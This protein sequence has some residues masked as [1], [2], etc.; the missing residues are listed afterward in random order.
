ME[1]ILLNNNSMFMEE[2][3]RILVCNDR[4]E[5][6]KYL[7]VFYVFKKDPMILVDELEKLIK[8]YNI[9]K[10]IKF[11]SCVNFVK[12]E[13]ENNLLRLNK[14]VR[15]KLMELNNNYRIVDVPLMNNKNI[16]EVSPKDIA[17]MMTKKVSN[18]YN[19][20]TNVEM[21]MRCK[22]YD[23]VLSPNIYEIIN[24]FENTS[25]WIPNIILQEKSKILQKKMAKWFINVMCECIKINNFHTCY[26]IYAGFNMICVSRLKYLFTKNIKIK[27]GLIDTLFNPSFNFRNY[28]EKIKE[29][30]INNFVLPYFG[31]FS[32]DINMLNEIPLYNDES[33]NNDV[34]D[35]FYNVVVN[36]LCHQKK[37]QINEK[38][39]FN[40][41]EYFKEIEIIRDPILLWEKSK[42][43]IGVGNLTSSVKLEKTDIEKLTHKSSKY[44]ATSIQF[45]NIGVKSVSKRSSR[46]LMNSVKLDKI[47]MNFVELN[48]INEFTN[49]MKRNICT[50]TNEDI[51]VWLNVIGYGKYESTF[52]LR[53][54][55]G[56]MLPFM[57]EKYLVE[58]LC[59]NEKDIDKLMDIINRFV[60]E[61]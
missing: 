28:R 15:N 35:K 34:I 4:E 49:R 24:N 20:I 61:K 1:I 12:L 46:Y 38:T 32:A 18:K 51:C 22:E 40:L 42:K 55:T 25:Y 3:K 26:A 37:F 47:D 19:K 7:T 57:N 54:I 43:I 56:I 39:N 6:L 58:I 14:G 50:W 60:N 11:E 31:I 30:N 2:M 53:N 23:K 13:L 44:L 10:K 33:I 29:L 52:R 8:R 41:S 21:L 27:L 16:F 59:V 9:N 17:I 48:E 5:Q 36:V 45:E